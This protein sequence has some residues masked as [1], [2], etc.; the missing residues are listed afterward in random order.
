VSSTTCGIAQHVGS[1][2][3]C[4]AVDLS[5][6]PSTQ[7]RQAKVYPTAGDQ[8]R[9]VIEQPVRG[10]WRAIIPL[11]IV[12]ILTMLPVT[13]VVPVLK[14][15]VQDR[16][17]VGDLPTSL[18]MSANMVGAILAAPLA[19]SLSDW[20]GRR[21]PLIIMA[22]LAD[23][24]LLA[25]LGQASNYATLMTLR[26]LE[27]AAH[28]FALSLLF[29]LAAD[30]SRTA[31]SGRIMGAVGTALTFGV[32]LGAPL[33]GVLGDASTLLPLWVGSGLALG[34]AAVTFLVLRDFPVSCQAESVRVAI[35]LILKH[36]PLLVPLAYS[37]VDR[38]TVGF[39]TTSFPL[40]MRN[41]HE[42]SP[43]E[44]GRLLALFLLP[45]ALF[46]YPFGRLTERTSRT[47]V[48][49]GGSLLYA[50]GVCTLGAV[51]LEILPFLMLGLGI[52]AAAMLV[53]TLMLTSEL[54]GPAGKATAMGGFNA[55][56]SLGFILGPLVAGSIS[57][58]VGG[59][60][61]PA[62]G[63]AT[64][65]QA[66]GASVLVCLIATLPTLV[67]LDWGRIKGPIQLSSMSQ[68]PS[69]QQQT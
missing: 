21:R 4:P 43:A 46:C 32:A 19:G 37:F 3:V 68:A 34:A 27:G 59:H 23:S 26:C 51:S 16:Y 47:L 53:P 9:S 56:G 14:P 50:L 13:L 17:G 25:L 54:A 69:D 48:L 33:G 7:K 8:M 42:L 58:W 12:T 18:F 52:V 1:P 11:G 22:L 38:F 39:F 40:Y 28:I 61:T 10:E 36:R 65:F 57:H 15:L 31:R 20:L 5:R 2:S 66:A 55:A 60:Y 45:F 63:Y 44:I 30:M 49:G 6:R 64:A 62:V 67:K 24:I 29:A 41:V 35:G